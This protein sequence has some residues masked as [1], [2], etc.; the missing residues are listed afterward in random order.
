[1]K[2]RQLLFPVFLFI[3]LLA[4]GSGIKFGRD[5][6]LFLIILA[7]A[8]FFFINKEKI[9]IPKKAGALAGLFLITAAV[10]AFVSEDLSRSFPHFLFL[11]S[12]IL[13]MLYAYNN[14]DEIKKSLTFTIYSLSGV[15]TGI[16]LLKQFLGLS[17]FPF[18]SHGY[19]LTHPFFYSHNHLGDFLVLSVILIVYSFFAQKKRNL[20]TIWILPAITM[21]VFSY[22]RSAYISLAFPLM[23][24]AFQK[25]KNKTRN[26]V[27][28]IAVPLFLLFTVFIFFLASS[29]ME[30]RSIPFLNSTH[31]ILVKNAGLFAYKSFFSDRP[32]YLEQGLRSIINH[33]LFG[34][35][36]DNFFYAS[37]ETTKNPFS[38]IVLT[39]HNIFLDKLAE[40]GVISGG[41]F[42]TFILLLF[43]KSDR[44]SFFLLALAML[45]NF[46][47]D[48]T[49]QIYSVFLL[50]CIFL[51]VSY[52]E[53]NV[54][55][56]SLTPFMLSL[57]SAFLGL[58]IL[59]SFLLSSLGQHKT[60]VTLYP[61]NRESYFPLITSEIKTGE[62]N[63][64]LKHTNNLALFFPN[65][66]QALIFAGDMFSRLNDKKK[67]FNLYDKGFMLD[68][69]RYPP[70]IKGLYKMKTEFEGKKSADDFLLTF[71]TK[72]Y[73][74]EHTWAVP[75]DY[76]M[77]LNKT[78]AEAGIRCPYV[79]H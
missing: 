55:V 19:Q 24:F 43:L 25:L 34:V 4:E 45:I 68:P 26:Q 7:P 20:G 1:M 2:I 28:K 37:R 52:K 65:D 17:L 22:S 40:L 18:A 3:I 13:L 16:L 74:L 29:I 27:I 46:Q 38:E 15:F 60:A 75:K 57:T 31:Q 63:S 8:F 76:F 50:F 51:C 72:I 58:I 64:A 59:L 41:L 9:Y 69:Y 33:P 71:Y 47:T 11:F 6:S 10:S 66:A 5:V 35:G 21:I 48:Y 70:L 32:K 12:A 73:N 14:K 53:E 79:V 23:F 56:K 30:S 61:L 42:I 77:T 54:T 49:F 36:G 44:K 39:S 67:A 62:D 78:C